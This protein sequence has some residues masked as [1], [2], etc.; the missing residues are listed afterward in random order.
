M[1]SVPL[2]TDKTYMPLAE[3][4]VSTGD[5]INLARRSGSYTALPELFQGN[6]DQSGSFEYTTCVPKGAASCEG[7][8]TVNVTVGN[9]QVK[10]DSGITTLSIS[11]NFLYPGYFEMSG[12]IT[13]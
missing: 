9:C 3:F 13:D 5:V 8:K 4:N 2:S 12:I 7:F 11:D 1:T 6:V 10:A